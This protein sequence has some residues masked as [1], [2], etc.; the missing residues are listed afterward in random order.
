MKGTT[1]EEIAEEIRSLPR[2]DARFF[3][4]STPESVGRALAR[5][6]LFCPGSW[7]RLIENERNEDLGLSSGHPWEFLQSVLVI[8]FSP[9]LIHDEET[10][11]GILDKLALRADREIDCAADE[12]E[13]PPDESV[14]QALARIKLIC[15]KTWEEF[16]AFRAAGEALP[17]SFQRRIVAILYEPPLVYPLWEKSGMFFQLRVVARMDASLTLWLEGKKL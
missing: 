6:L 2:F 1:P 3:T 17:E 9:C 15:A 11:R 4:K 14:Q 7:D 16:K 8:M 10:R 5:V 12:A 13:F